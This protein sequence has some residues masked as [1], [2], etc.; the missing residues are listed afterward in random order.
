MQKHKLTLTLDVFPQLVTSHLLLLVLLLV[1]LCVCTW[2][3]NDGG[4]G[5]CF[6]LMSTIYDTFSNFSYPSV[7]VLFL[8][9]PVMN[10]ESRAAGVKGFL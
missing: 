7:S 10:F 9:V 2:S 4:A 5:M 3:R 8:N 6:V 1:L